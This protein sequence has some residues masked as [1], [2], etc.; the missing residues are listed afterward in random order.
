MKEPWQMTQLEWE[1]ARDSFRVQGHGLYKVTR[2]S[3]A[4]ETARIAALER[5][6]Y[7]VRDA[8]RAII[9]ACAA[10]YEAGQPAPYS[11]EQRQRAR[12]RLDQFVTHFD[13]IHKALQDGQPVPAEVLA[14][15]KAYVNGL[16]RRYEERQED[17]S[18]ELIEAM[19]VIRQFENRGVVYAEA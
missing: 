12:E 10:A 4:Q 2:A 13:V 16:V 5:H 17:V 18:E 8:D 1:A 3:G 7:G 11:M 9:N 19:D 14:E 6:L 15:H